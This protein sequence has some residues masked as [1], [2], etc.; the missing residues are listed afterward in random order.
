M[1]ESCFCICTTPIRQRWATIFS[2]VVAAAITLPAA[3]QCGSGGD[4]CSASGGLGCNDVACCETVCA[5]DPF[6]CETAW[7]GICAGEAAVNCPELCTGETD[8]DPPLTCPP[9]GLQ[10]NEKDCGLPVD[11]VNGGCNSA[12]VGAGSGNCC[13]AN[14]GLGCEDDVCEASVCALDPFCCETAWDGICAGEAAADPNCDCLGKGFPVTPI[15]CGDTYCG[16]GAFDAGLG[17][18]DTDWYEITIGAETELVW[19]VTAEFPPVLFILDGNCPATVVAGAVIGAPCTETTLSACVGP[20]TYRLFV[21]TDFV[22]AACPSDY[23]ATLTCQSPCQPQACCFSD[24][25]C[26]DLTQPNCLAA[27]GTPQGAGTDCST[28][29]CPEICGKSNPNDCCVASPTGTPGC[30]DSECCDVV[31]SLDPFCCDVAWDG[32]CAGSAIANCQTLCC[33][34]PIENDN[35]EDRIDVD[36]GTTS[37]TTVCSTTDGPAACAGL[38]ANDI[39]YNYTASCTGEVTFDTFGSAYDTVLAVYDGCEC[40][41]GIEIACNDDSGSLQSQVV[42]SVVEGNCYKIQVGGFFGA[43]GTGVLNITKGAGVSD[44][45][46]D[47]FPPGAGDGN[48][49]AGDLGQLLANWGD[50]SKGEGCG[51]PADIFPPGVTSN[52]CEPNGGL[53]CDNDKCEA[54]V[55]GADAFCCDV[56]WDGLCSAAAQTL[57]AELCG[58]TQGDGEVDAGDLGQLLANWGDCF[59]CEPEPV[60]CPDGAIVEDEPNCGLP[61]DTVNGGCNYVPNLFGTIE[62]GDTIC[63]R[64]QFDGT[65]RDLDWFTLT[66]EADTQVTLTAIAEFDLVLFYVQA[67]CPGGPAVFS[68]AAPACTEA[69]LTQCLTAG[70]WYVVIAADFTQP[71]GCA[72]YTATL[73]CEGKCVA[74]STC[75]FASGG[76]GC[77]DPVCTDCVCT[78]DPFC[79]DVAWDGLCAGAALPGGVCEGSCPCSG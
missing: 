37:F 55:C 11:T 14:G 19:T 60:V 35:C 12:P 74:P 1:N 68:V 2:A 57:C 42:V 77:D 53:G 61:T 20:G 76:I 69:T 54:A 23:V 32:L 62:C 46:A 63:G 43:V 7:D 22:P 27:G 25:T 6:C 44:C 65:T 38:M 34:E 45:P 17:L 64:G 49:D 71:T 16:S 67:P 26:Q 73:T 79:C 41:V 33:P 47:L 40:P 5:L 28:A 15:E 50:C 59:G 52:C 78:N 8:C 29:V 39:W 9:G 56:A 75:C 18:R 10:E 24:G 51:C 31:C 58:A 36:N 21:A 3:A 66:L 13:I 4:C 30:N 72:D 70:E 48:V